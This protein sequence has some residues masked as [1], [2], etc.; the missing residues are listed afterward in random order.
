MMKYINSQVYIIF[1][2]LMRL[3]SFRR[4]DMS[5]VSRQASMMLTMNERSL[6]MDG[7]QRP[8]PLCWIVLVKE[9][10]A[11]QGVTIYQK[12]P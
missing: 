9:I 3:G 6:I 2:E 12:R 8:C 1:P 10:H 5:F 11:K 7:N 4:D